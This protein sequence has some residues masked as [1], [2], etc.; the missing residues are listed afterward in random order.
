[1]TQ[2]TGA[3]LDQ[4]FQHVTG[5]PIT[6][7][8]ASEIT[9]LRNGVMQRIRTDP[10]FATGTMTAGDMQN[11]VDLEITA[12]LQRRADHFASQYGTSAQRLNLAP[13][14]LPTAR[15]IL[16]QIQ[17]LAPHFPV[18]EAT[19]SQALLRANATFQQLDA[20]PL[21]DPEVQQTITNVQQAVASLQQH[22][23]LLQG[24]F[25]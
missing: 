19:L 14:Q 21:S 15:N 23:L 25:G 17:S 20:C 4:R 10:R 22:Q 24:L 1:M 12:V 18:Q 6:T 5:Q 7:L 11:L 16:N 8:D 3:D 13:H 2:A 9:A